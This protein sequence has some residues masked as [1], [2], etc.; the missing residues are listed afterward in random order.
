MLSKK[1]SKK[2]GASKFW[3]IGKLYFIRTVTLYHVGEL[4]AIDDH[5]ITLRDTAWVVDTGRF[6]EALRTGQCAEVEPFQ[7]GLTVVGRGALIDAGPWP[8][9]PLRKVI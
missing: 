5:E 1:V 2:T 3:V 7:D 6:A 4:V 8:H 9:P